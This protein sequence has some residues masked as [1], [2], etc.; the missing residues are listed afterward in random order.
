MTW[1]HFRCLSA[2]VKEDGFSRTDFV[3]SGTFT[4]VFWYLLNIVCT[5]IVHFTPSWFSLEL[6][7]LCK[8]DKKSEEFAFGVSFGFSWAHFQH[9]DLPASRCK[10]THPCTGMGSYSEL[11]GFSGQ[12]GWILLVTRACSYFAVLIPS[13]WVDHPIFEVVPKP[14]L[15]EM[16]QWIWEKHNWPSSACL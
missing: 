11:Q 2:S 14:V 12:E 10:Y 15:P 7:F 3:D 16:A 5:F 1:P 6:L 8:G 9:L 4:K 13:L